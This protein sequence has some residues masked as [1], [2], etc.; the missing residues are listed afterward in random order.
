M[1]GAD[2]FKRA[3]A[4]HADRR[5]ASDRRAVLLVRFDEPV[6]GGGG[7]AQACCAALPISTSRTREPTSTAAAPVAS[8]GPNHSGLR[9]LPGDEERVSARRLA[10]W[11]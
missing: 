9:E 7:P 6:V 5:A 3:W 11:L 4:G 10:G 8:A 2:G 1:V